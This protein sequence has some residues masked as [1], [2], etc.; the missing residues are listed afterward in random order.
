MTGGA[1][2]IGSHLCEELLAAGAEVH[3]ADN[4]SAGVNN[5]HSIR[6]GDR[7]RFSNTDLSDFKQAEK[8]FDKA[9]P[10]AVFHFAAFPRVSV[11]ADGE[12]AHLNNN[13]IATYNI[14]E[15]VRYCGAKKFVFASTCTVYGRTKQIPTPE[16][17]PL[18]P[19]SLYGA[20][21]AACEALASS[22]ADNYAFSS[23]VVRYA[24]VVGARSTHGVTYDFVNKL[25]KNHKK[26]EV[27]GDGTQEK[28][29]V[30]VEDAVKA[31]LLAAEK[32]S[33][34]FDVFNVGSEDS[35]SALQI[36]Q[37][38]SSKMRLKPKIVCTGG[39][40]WKGDV[41]KM[42]LDCTKIRKLGWKPRYNSAQAVE[43]TVEGLI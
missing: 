24:N 7:I 33:L 40:A 25:D 8:F 38:V 15:A 19:V 43:K 31:T 16:T 28:S 21:K 34:P 39:E 2:F 42:L 20:S 26:L 36:A 12:R 30:F 9:E 18:K 6:Y 4:L 22:F 41:T 17:E 27:L 37:I 1:G 3:V 5:I 29:Y 23:T 32:N 10:Q 14:L 11:G 13:V 35:L